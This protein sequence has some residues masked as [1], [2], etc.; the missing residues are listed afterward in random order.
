MSKKN[1]EI[2]SPEEL[3]KLKSGEINQTPPTVRQHEWCPCGS[4]KKFRKCCMLKE[5][6]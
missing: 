3:E 5:A 4:G 6:K 1:R 2:Y